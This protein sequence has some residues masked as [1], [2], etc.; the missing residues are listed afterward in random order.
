MGCRAIEKSRK[1]DVAQMGC[2]ATG[3]SRRWDIAQL[4]C[5]ATG[6]SRRWDV[7][8]MG[9]RAIEMSRIWKVAQMVCRAIEMS[10]RWDIAQKNVAQMMWTQHRYVNGFRTSLREP[11]REF[12]SHPFQ[13]ATEYRRNLDKGAHSTPSQ[14][15]IDSHITSIRWDSHLHQYYTGYFSRANTTL[16]YAPIIR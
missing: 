10:R 9:Y 15:L 1:W 6:L 2:R 4:K 14:L 13:R 12:F 3:K 16:R 11:F 8:Q 5:R 7:A